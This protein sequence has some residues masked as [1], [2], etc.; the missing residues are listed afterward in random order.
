[1]LLAAAVLAG[2]AA[3][4]WRLWEQDVFWQVRAGRELLATAHWPTVDTWSY[5]AAGGP[6]RNFQW[7]STVVMA[8]A[9]ALAGN[10][11]L[12]L[13][14]DLAVAG[15]LLIMTVVL[16][17]RGAQLPVVL[18]LLGLVWLACARRFQ[19]RSDLFVTLVFALVLALE[20]SFLAWRTR[21]ILLVALVVLAANLHPG[22]ALF[23]ELAALVVLAADARGWRREI[24]PAAGILL[25]LLA[26]PYHFEVAPYLWR[27]LFYAAYSA[28][29]NPD[30]RTLEV[31]DF[32]PGA[33]GLSPMAWLV[34]VAAAALV[35]FHQARRQGRAV[36]AR[37]AL[38]LTFLTLLA[39]MSVNRD[40]VMPYA[41]IF[42]AAC[43]ADFFAARELARR[44]TT[45][46][47]AAAG[48]IW[49][50]AIPAW[51]ARSEV[52]FGLGLDERMLPVGAAGFIAT[53]RPQPQLLHFQGDGDYLLR[54]LPEY[55]V[56]LDTRESMY[57]ELGAAYRDM[58]ND[59][60]VFGAVMTRYGVGTVM[61]PE[62]FL[63]TGWR[64]GI[65]RR[66]AFL[67]KREWALVYF[68]ATHA[69]FVRRNPAHASLIAEHEYELLLPYRDP[70]A[71]LAL[72]DR[73]VERDQAFRR[74]V[75]RC[76]QEVPSLLHC[77]LAEAALPDL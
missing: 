60:P 36:R 66:A 58:V 41:A 31:A 5:T 11:G 62:S 7:L 45:I 33:G 18:G 16:R 52:R 8:L 59:P 76:R 39:A 22:T 74:E 71:Y 77:R 26:T 21:R 46:A 32:L 57:E 3:S 25:G 6:W 29:P 34:L 73:T 23:V 9:D 28:V 68:D 50:V 19:V 48:V 20:S 65:T 61:V 38:S 4:T 67:P 56:F 54:A 69:V 40:R 15:L 14:R 42:A 64:N 27:H 72:R 37:E 1:L 70:R 24:L 12:V 49:L 43:V 75:E 44:W 35:L 2:A 53:H 17:R 63:M 55:P 13:L 10:V 47:A 51:L 30:H